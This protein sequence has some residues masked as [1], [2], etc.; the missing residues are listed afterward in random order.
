MQEQQL[1]S[2]TVHQDMEGRVEAQSLDKQ[3]SEKNLVLVTRVGDASE[4]TGCHTSKHT[5][6][7]FSAQQSMLKAAVLAR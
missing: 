6:L 3:G 5:R 4:H 1:A 7:R 2:L